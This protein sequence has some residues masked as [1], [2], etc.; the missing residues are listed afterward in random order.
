MRRSYEY[1]N[2]K[3]PID[4][5]LERLTQMQKTPTIIVD[6]PPFPTVHETLNNNPTPTN[7]H[8]DHPKIMSHVNHQKQQAPETHKK[9]HF[10]EQGKGDVQAP[11]THKK[12]HFAEQGKHDVHEGK[13]IDVE[14]DGFIQ[15]K[16]RT[17]ELRKWDTFKVY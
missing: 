13:S 5:Y 10:A 6:Y 3:S 16:H 1:H 8:D 11:E 4:E 14:A 9:V 15:Q 7:K 17:F 2:S 12:V